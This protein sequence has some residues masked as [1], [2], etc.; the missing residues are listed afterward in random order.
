MKMN[1]PHPS[2]EV[3]ESANAATTG[4]QNAT[5]NINKVKRDFAKALKSV[6]AAGNC[7]VDVASRAN[8][9]K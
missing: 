1:G 9:P 3:I 7:A 4:I 5:S 6:P 2:F 8:A